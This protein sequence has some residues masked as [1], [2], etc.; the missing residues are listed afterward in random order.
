MCEKLDFEAMAVMNLEGPVF[1]PGSNVERK[2]ASKAGPTLFN[3]SLPTSE[4]LILLSLANN[5][6]MDFGPKGLQVSINQIAELE[7]LGYF[8]AG[9]SL[10]EAS[11]A[12]FL[13][14]EGVRVAIISR[15]ERQFGVASG[16][17]PGSAVLDAT[18]YNDIASLKQLV[19]HLVVLIHGGAEMIPW[20]SP[21]R[22]AEWKTYIEAGASVVVGNHS[23]VPSAWETHREGVIFY[24]L[25]NFCV[26]PEKWQWHPQGLWSLVP[27]FHFSKSS[28]DFKIGTRV[29]EVNP[30]S[31]RVKRPDELERLVHED[32][33]AR[34]NSL[35]S[36]D[37]S[38]IACWQEASVLLY[39]RYF[40]TW[41]GFRTNRKGIL[42]R[43]RTFL[44]HFVSLFIDLDELFRRNRDLV[45]FHLFACQS[46]QEVISTALGVLAGEIEDLRT[47]ESRSMV[48]SMVHLD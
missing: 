4:N 5:H 7:N 29:L 6:I 35:F 14:R 28:F 17:T 26:N 31:L 20:P 32:F 23:H 11:V 41:L 30:K 27:E 12:Y 16:A 38:L 36:D 40:A 34:V 44:P 13:E 45:R 10:E 8:G 48:K 37:S 2:P 21:S 43:I 22:R 33:I 3:S 42:G 15:T 18:I 46:H 9:L 1:E 47:P 39:E 24:G 19:D 25:G